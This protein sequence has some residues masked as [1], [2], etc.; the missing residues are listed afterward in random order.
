[1]LAG[2]KLIIDPKWIFLAIAWFA[3]AFALSN[4]KYPLWFEILLVILFFAFSYIV[5]DPSILSFLKKQF[6]N[7]IKGWGFPVIED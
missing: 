6:I 4:R 5:F 1:L 3:L 7:L 2:E